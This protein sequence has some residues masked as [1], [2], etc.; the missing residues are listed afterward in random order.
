MNNNF[1][2]NKK[3]KKKKNTKKELIKIKKNIK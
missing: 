2:Q 3:H 1:V